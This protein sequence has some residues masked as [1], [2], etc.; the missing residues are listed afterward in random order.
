M[1]NKQHNGFLNCSKFLTL[2]FMKIKNPASF[3]AGQ[4]IILA[5]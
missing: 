3:Q 2:D 5:V 1:Y 4:K